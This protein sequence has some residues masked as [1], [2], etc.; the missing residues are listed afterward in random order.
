MVAAAG[1]DL[2]IYI[3][4]ARE[5]GLFSRQLPQVGMKR[6]EFDTV[7]PQI[8]WVVGVFWRAINA[9]LIRYVVAPRSLLLL[10]HSVHF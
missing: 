6:H 2:K 1:F 5:L 9:R 8:F 10:D 3:F 7:L 4:Y